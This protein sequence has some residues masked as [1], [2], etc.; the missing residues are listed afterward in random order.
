MATIQEQLRP[1]KAKYD[2]EKTRMDEHRILKQKLDELKAKL[3]E[4]ERNYELE[5]AADL[6]FYG[7]DIKLIFN[8][9]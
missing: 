5:K 6:R 3:E 7:I 9:S 4:S 8:S 1:L 2:L